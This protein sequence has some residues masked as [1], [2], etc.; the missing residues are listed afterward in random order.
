MVCPVCKAEMTQTVHL[1]SEGIGVEYHLTPTGWEEF[2][3]VET[4]RADIACGHC[5]S[6]IDSTE[7]GFGEL[8]E[9]FPEPDDSK[10]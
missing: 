4:S 9:E 5:M 3:R 2:E 8:L 7:P 6:I 1:L 10:D